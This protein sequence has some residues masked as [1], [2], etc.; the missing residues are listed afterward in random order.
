MVDVLANDAATNPFPGE[1]LRVVSVRGLNARDLPA[2][3]SVTPSADKSQ[4]TVVVA[5]S[6]K[7]SDTTLEYEVAD[8]TNDADRFTWGTIS[9]SVQDVPNAP[10]APARASGFTSAQLT[11]SWPAPD[12]NN[13]PITS[14]TVENDAGYRH[15][16]TSTVCTLTGLPTGERTRFSVT[17]TNSIGTSPPSPWSSLLSAD[18]VPD[19]PAAVTLRTVAA[20]DSERAGHPEGG[21]IIADWSAVS[22]PTGGSRLTTYRVVILEG[23]G[24]VTQFDVAAG[25]TTSPVLWLS[26][27]HA[28]QARVTPLNDADTSDWQSTTS[29]TVVAMGPPL[30]AGGNGFAH[31]HGSA[32]W[33]CVEPTR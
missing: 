24:I 27:G 22:D 15:V 31:V 8:A 11:L 12:A 9:I 21:G 13:A 20:A 29:A 2:G 3:V 4:L 16:C 25:T 32:P 30:P 6:A 18:I 10:A 7:A 19:A 1:P 33:R 28:Y 5:M 23:G 14:Y 17:A 26:A